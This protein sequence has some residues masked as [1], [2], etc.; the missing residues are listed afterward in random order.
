MSTPRIS[1]AS[2]PSFCQKLSKLA[3]IWW[4]SD[5]NNFA[6]F[7]ETRCSFHTLVIKCAII[8]RFVKFYFL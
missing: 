7:F 4:N 3:K 5:K 2:L 8:L 1:L 6:Q